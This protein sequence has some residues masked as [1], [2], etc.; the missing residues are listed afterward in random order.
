MD[1]GALR[2]GNADLVAQQL[3][4]AMHGY[5]MLDLAGLHLTS[6]DPEE[7]VFRPLIVTLLAGLSGKSG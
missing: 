4:T 7:E 1:L 5:V 3:W 2:R 6:K